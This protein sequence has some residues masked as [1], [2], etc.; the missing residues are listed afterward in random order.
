MNNINNKDDFVSRIEQLFT[1]WTGQPKVDILL[2]IGGTSPYQEPSMI[3]NN[4]NGPLHCKAY[5]R[6]ILNIPVAKPKTFSCFSKLLWFIWTWI[7]F[8]WTWLQ[9]T[10]SHLIQAAWNYTTCVCSKLKYFLI[11][12]VLCSNSCLKNGFGGQRHCFSWLFSFPSS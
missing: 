7:W 6:G 12:S 1:L 4:M 10:R 8:I 3:L 2:Q 11:D 9:D 5:N